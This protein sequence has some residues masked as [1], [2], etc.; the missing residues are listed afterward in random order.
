MSS[1]LLI[2]I[3]FPLIGVAIIAAL[4]PLGQA[5]VRQ[6]AL[7]TAIITL[8]LAATVVVRYPHAERGSNGESPVFAQSELA[9]L[10]SSGTHSPINIEFSVGLDGLSVWLFGLSALLTFTA[11]LI[12]WDSIRERPAAFYAMLLLLETGMLGVFA[13]RDI[14]LFYIF[15]EFTLIPLFFLIGIWGS[16]ERR[17]AAVKFFLFTF[18]GSLLTFLGLLTLV[19]WQYWNSPN[20]E[21]EFNIQR[22]T[23]ALATDLSWHDPDHHNWQLLVFLAL[24]AGF[25]IKVP[26]FPLHTWLPLAHTQAPAA[27]SVLLAGVLLKIG[28]YGF[29]RFSLPMLPEAAAICIPWLLWLSVI[30]IVYGALLALAQT[31]MKRLIACSS[32]SHLGFCML[33]LFAL[34]S[35][36]MQGGVLQMLNHGI[37][38]GALFALIGML[39]DRYHTRQISALGGIARR[40]PRLTFFMLLFT[41]SSIGLPGLNGFAG[42]FPILLGMFQR[43][44]AEAPAGL[45]WELLV[46][47]VLAVSGVVL[48]AWYMLWLVQRVFFGPLREPNTATAGPAGDHSHAEHDVHISTGDHPVRDMNLREVLALAPL[49]VFVFWIGLIPGTFL[50]AI[51]PAVKEVEEA[52]AAP[53]DEQYTS[54]T[55]QVVRGQLSVVSGRKAGAT[56]NGQRTTD[57]MAVQGVGP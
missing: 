48:G 51:G 23:A 11:V 49:A 27:G 19:L 7:V 32:V 29:L 22:L 53:F 34:N 15:F 54:V 35:L 47:A 3:F 42:E 26:L 30:G 14:I 16:E 44:W 21:L 36:G 5:A 52:V 43:G 28:C 12:S 57:N 38:T 37:S 2:T 8:V 10:S 31:D 20:H 17:H 13:A 39:Y 24:F 41:L 25:A 9:W 33:G 45:G 50:Q 56:D 55:H 40:M 1:V 6:S 4:A 18:A 46:I